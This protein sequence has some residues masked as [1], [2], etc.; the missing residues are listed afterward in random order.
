[1]QPWE[2]GIKDSESLVF[3]GSRLFWRFLLPE[4]LKK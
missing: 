2:N 1:M 4:P 3:W